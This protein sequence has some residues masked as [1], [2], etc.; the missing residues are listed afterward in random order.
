MA[1]FEKMASDMVLKDGEKRPFA[2]TI[3]ISARGNATVSFGPQTGAAIMG[4]APEQPADWQPADWIV[5]ATD[6]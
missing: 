6:A 4:S 3:M 5:R 1:T 2:V